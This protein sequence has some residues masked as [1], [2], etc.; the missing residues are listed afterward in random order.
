MLRIIDNSNFNEVN[1]NQFTTTQ[2]SRLTFECKTFQQFCHRMLFAFVD[3]SRN[4]AKY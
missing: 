3:L 4:F 2:K 1:A